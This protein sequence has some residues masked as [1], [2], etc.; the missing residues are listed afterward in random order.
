M[1]EPGMFTEY[2]VLKVLMRNYKNRH[3]PGDTYTQ[4]WNEA[5]LAVAT[6]L[7]LTLNVL[8]DKHE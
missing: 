8:E 7:G 3:R 4:A 2:E 1:R 5:L 6:D